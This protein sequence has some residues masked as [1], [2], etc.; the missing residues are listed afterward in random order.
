M[1]LADIP[2]MVRVQIE[3]P[4][5]SRIKRN[6]RGGIDYVSPLSCPFNYGSVPN[7]ESADGEPLDAIVLG[8][9]LPLGHSG[10]Y[11]V[12]GVVD[13]VD[14]GQEDPKVICIQSR[15]T[16]ADRTTI[17]SFFET[18]ARLKGPINRLRGRGGPTVFRGLQERES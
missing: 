7:T 15:M 6:P 5:G 9:T 3:V 16:D 4:K 10:D 12:V 1:K 13:F 2:H 14:A 8:S 18:Y 11:R 17:T